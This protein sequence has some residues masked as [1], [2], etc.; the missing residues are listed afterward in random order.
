LA[1]TKPQLGVLLVLVLLQG[2]MLLMLLHVPV[3]VG[4]RMLLFHLVDNEL[5][6]VGPL[7]LSMVVLLVLW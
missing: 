7:L 6:F 5:M 2:V 3:L 1:S 4:G